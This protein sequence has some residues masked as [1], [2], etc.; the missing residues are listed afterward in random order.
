[1]LS[2][3]VV[4]VGYESELL[5]L[6]SLLME[7]CL[8]LHV[9]EAIDLQSALRGV[10]N[11]ERID[12]VVLCH[13]VPCDDQ[14]MIIE[15]AR[16]HGRN[17]PTLSIFPGMCDPSAAGTPVSNDPE[18]LLAALRGAVAFSTNGHER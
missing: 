7:R 8:G 14:A 15:A 13:T 16:D 17:I 2:S 12:A 1:M 9:L 5:R 10:Q 11:G 3:K 4:S 6:R 18:Q